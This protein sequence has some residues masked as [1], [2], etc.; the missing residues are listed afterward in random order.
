MKNIKSIFFTILL[1]TSNSFSQTPDNPQSR[2]CYMVL[3]GKNASKSGSIMLAHN[4]DLTGN[5]PSFIEIIPECNDTGFTSITYPNGLTI[6]LAA[7]T[8]RVLIQRIQNGF[9]EGDAVAINQY[10]VSIAGG[11]ALGSDRNVKAK[12]FA[13]L[14]ENGLPG[15]IRYDI[16]ARSKTARECVLKLGEA[17][18]KYGVTY[19]SGVGI[20]DTSEIWYIECGGGREWAAV[21]IPDSCYWVQANGYRI[22]E[23]DTSKNEFFLTS[24]GLFEYCKNVNLWDPASGQFNFAKVFGGGRTEEDGGLEYDRLRVWR[25]IDLLSPS[26]NLSATEDD[27]PI[28]LKPDELISELDLFKL[29]RDYFKR[30]SYDV[31]NSNENEKDI[32]AIASWRGVHSSLIV[33]SN[34]KPTNIGAVLWSGIGSS[35]VT[36]FIPVPF[37]V[38]AIPFTYSNG[39]E[40]SAFH[41]FNQLARRSKNDWEK[42]DI[43]QHSFLENE[44]RLLNKYKRLLSSL[45]NGLGNSEELRMFTDHAA[46]TTIMVLLRQIE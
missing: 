46:E 10:G 41:M 23:I 8:Y 33:I 5:E 22:G 39:E 45:K 36:G 6:N 15:G 28:Y 14:V 43:I 20:A 11:V 17:Y 3:V 30:T 34:S 35:L 38:E 42:I 40:G 19:P 44:K 27:L 24:P 21:R 1:I 26:L 2:E 18:S 31:R 32:R 25:G 9:D 7:K 4:N 29:L 37:G 16:L 13:P 12:H